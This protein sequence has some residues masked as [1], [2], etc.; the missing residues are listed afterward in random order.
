[1]IKNVKR[2]DYKLLRIKG[3]QRILILDGKKYLWT[4]DKTYG[5]RL[6]LAPKEYEEAC[7]LSVGHYRIYSVKDDS[8]FTDQFHLELLI[9]RGKWQGYLLPDGLPSS[10]LEKDSLQATKET[11]TNTSY[12]MSL[13]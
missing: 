11:I 2:G 7:V 9:G 12:N 1:M 4:Y 13:A 8:T 6:E 3:D 10:R 5:D